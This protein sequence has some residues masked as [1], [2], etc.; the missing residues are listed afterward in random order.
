LTAIL[1]AARRHY[2]SSFIHSIIISA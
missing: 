1:K 2:T